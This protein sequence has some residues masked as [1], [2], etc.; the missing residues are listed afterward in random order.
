MAGTSPGVTTNWIPPQKVPSKGL[1]YG[2]LS[3]YCGVAP[4]T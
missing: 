4:P 3:D 2:D 1:N